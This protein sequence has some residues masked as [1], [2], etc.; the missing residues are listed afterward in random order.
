[1]NANKNAKTCNGT[2]IRKEKAIVAGTNHNRLK[3]EAELFEILDS[4]LMNEKKRWDDFFSQLPNDH[5]LATALPDE[6]LYDYLKNRRVSIGQALDIGCGN[7]RNSAFLAANGFNV[8]AI[9]ISSEAL[10]MAKELSE[11]RNTNIS[12]A[13]SSLLDF[14]FKYEFYDLAY[15]FGCLHH[16]HPHR[17]PQYI[18]KIKSCLKPKAFFALGTFNQKMGLTTGDIDV[19][20]N[21]SMEGGLSFSKEDLHFLFA[22]DF[23][24]LEIREMKAQPKESEAVGW[25]HMTVSLWQKT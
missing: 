24:C 23:T 25:E 3:S 8:D 18:E 2:N 15:D 16:I 22:K 9:D 11:K 13:C 14:D 19:Y 21:Q 4:L 10:A 17:R 5:P 6:H 7:G 20:K 12:F 1:M